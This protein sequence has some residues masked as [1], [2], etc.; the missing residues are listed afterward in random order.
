LPGHAQGFGSFRFLELSPLGRPPSFI[1]KR[2][3]VSDAAKLYTGGSVTDGLDYGRALLD[4]Y[5]S[6]LCR[7][8]AMWIEFFLG[9]EDLRVP[10]LR[11]R[12]AVKV[13]VL[14]SAMIHLLQV[15]FSLWI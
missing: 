8:L 2:Y 15:G 12:Q 1:L 13:M 3:A 6:R 5:L 7:F 9:G 11:T 14:Y 10:L 4:C